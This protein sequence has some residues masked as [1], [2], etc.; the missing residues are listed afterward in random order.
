[1]ANIN[2]RQFLGEVR[3][4]IAKVSWPTRKEA[5]RLTFIVILISVFV[6]VFIGLTDF[7]FT[8]TVTGIL[9]K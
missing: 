7:I 5:A 9:I 1:M 2:P 6:G 8:K 3:N 4:E